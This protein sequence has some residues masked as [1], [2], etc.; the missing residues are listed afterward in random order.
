MNDHKE[1]KKE[2]YTEI[3]N[4]HLQKDVTEINVQND[5]K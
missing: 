3:K 5:Q 4:G 1:A 2:K